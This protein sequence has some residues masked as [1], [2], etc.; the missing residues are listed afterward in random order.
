[1]AID[2]AKY[3]VPTTPTTTGTVN[4]NK[5]KLNAPQKP[6]TIGQRILDA[7]TSVT[8]FLGGKSVADTFGAEIAR[9]RAPTQQEKN[10]IS[11]G[12][13]TVSQTAG[14]ALQLAA[15]FAPVGRA[16]QAISTGAK[17]LGATPSLAK[18]AGNVGS[19]GG[20]GYAFDIGANL[21]EQQSPLTPGAGTAIGA[22]LPVIPPALKGAARLGFESLGATTGVGG[23]VTKR[24]FD[25][26]RQGGPRAQQAAQALRGNITPEQIVDDARDAL[27]Q[28]ITNRTRTYQQQLAKIAGGLKSYDISPVIK[29]LDDNLK[30]FKIEVRN[31]Q[32][33][34]SRSTIRFDREAQK[35]VQTIFD[36]M[37]TFGTRPGDRTAVG[38]DSL[39]RALGDL[40]SKS[41]NVRAFTQDVKNATRKVL[42]QVKGYDDMTKG[43]EESTQLIKEIQRGLSLGDQAQTDTAFRKLVSALRVNNEFRQQL[44]K[45][46]DAVSGKELSSQIAGQQMSELLP[47]GVV[48]QIGTVGA[49]GGVAT[50]FAI[51]L[52][53]AAL[54]FSPRVVGEILTALGYTARKA[55]QI[56]SK[57]APN[58]F[59]APGDAFLDSQSG[60]AAL[61]YAKNLQPGLSMRNVSGRLPQ[62]PGD[63]SFPGTTSSRPSTSAGISTSNARSASEGGLRRTTSTSAP[64]YGALQ[65]KPFKGFKDLTTALLSDLEGRATV[66]K[67]YLLDAT[68]RGGLKQA[69][70][71]LFRRLLEDEGEVIAAKDFAKRVKTELLPLK[72]ESIASAG[73]GTNYENITLSDELR[74]PIANYDEHIYESPISTSAGNVHFNEEFP[75]YFAHTRIEDLPTSKAEVSPLYAGDRHIY[76]QKDVYSKEPTRRVIEIQSDLF[77][78]GRLEGEASTK[79][80][81]PPR[82]DNKEY[83]DLTWQLDRLMRNSDGNQQERVAAMSKIKRRMQEILEDYNAPRKAAREAELSRLE[84]YRN[85]WWERIVREE[86]KQAAK[87]GKTKL[88]FPTGETAMKIEGLGQVDT[89]VTTR[90]TKIGDKTYPED[91]FLGRETQPEVGMVIERTAG[92][93]TYTR[94]NRNDEWI[95]TDV[96][97]DGKFKA[98]PK[99][100]IELQ[101]QNHEPFYQEYYAVSRDKDPLSDAMEN[102]IFDMKNNNVDKRVFDSMTEQFDISGKVDTNNP[103]YRFYEKDVQKYLTK[104]YGGK[105]I[106][107][108]RGVTWIEILV[109]KDAAKRP[110]EAFAAGTL[111]LVPPALGGKED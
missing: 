109:P 21:Q 8:N 32:L 33:D 106:T 38:I 72:R 29:S 110:V 2:Y 80:E 78:K 59:Q 92:T 18:L 105:V 70:R 31:G 27:S 77:Q 87:D 17:T 5:Y 75:N 48:R 90:Q 93:D 12:A 22:A 68:N 24:M 94:A 1:M 64:F 41:S 54:F 20:A 39:K 76:G 66:S 103:I 60:K 14:S 69:E 16:A 10:I 43:Y 42:S 65:P 7:G 71:D 98:V 37:R 53:K 44:I 88:Q 108:D 45:E 51:P 49:V 73:G 28:I 30:R 63:V 11:A 100:E 61:N 57:I 101:L 104:K 13:P 74:G 34:F 107:D 50:G 81:I 23:A 85:T 36:E 86:V 52:I 83:T 99:R 19:L 89:W 97:G 46:L 82:G 96:L 47:R 25:A 3:K 15:G 40:Y 91:L 84:P 26:A 6:K 111:P 4:Y 56:I 55:D 9:L 58:G 62:N 35:E 67:Q 102:F 95:I 79:M